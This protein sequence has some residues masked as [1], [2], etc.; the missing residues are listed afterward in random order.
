VQHNLADLKSVAADPGANRNLMRLLGEINEDLLCDT[1]QLLSPFDNATKAVSVD[2]SPSLHLVLPTK[3]RLQ[4]HLSPVGSDCEVI[5]ELRRHLQVQLEQ[6]FTVS[7]LHIAASLLDPRLKDNTVVLSQEL[8]ASAS[9]TVR[10]M[11]SNWLPAAEASTSNDTAENAQPQTV[12][13]QQP[14]RK[15][16]CLDLDFF[17]DIFTSGQTVSDDDELDLYLKSGEWFSLQLHCK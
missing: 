4:K 2:K 13:D 9:R 3:I 1:I 6:Y 16:Q 5:A 11:M 15:R 14:P 7:D 17:G 12:E 10:E 8:R